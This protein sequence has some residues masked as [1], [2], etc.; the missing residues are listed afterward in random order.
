[1]RWISKFIFAGV[2]GLCA[3]PAQGARRG[4]GAALAGHVS[5]GVSAASHAPTRS[6][7]PPKTPTVGG[8]APAP[9]AVHKTAAVSA[10]TAGA[11]AGAVFDNDPVQDLEPVSDS[12]IGYVSPPTTFQPA[13]PS[14]DEIERRNSRSHSSDAS[15]ASTDATVTTAAPATGDALWSRIDAAGSHMQA[16]LSSQ[17]EYWAAVARLASAEEKV[18]ALR[19]DSRTDADQI[20]LAAQKVTEV[21]EEL[22]QM[23]KSTLETDPNFQAA[24]TRND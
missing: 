16:V 19:A 5:S 1:M 14:Y 21:Q 3:L 11:G 13:L 22:F 8:A 24:L 6:P 18:A 17:P 15:R 9:V 7:K 20:R 23:Q 10:T 2:R 4:N 12:P